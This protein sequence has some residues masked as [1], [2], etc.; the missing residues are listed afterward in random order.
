MVMGQ[1][2]GRVQKLG[3]ISIIVIVVAS[4]VLF[5]YLQSMTENNIK[6]RLFDQQKQKQLDSTMLYHNILTHL[7]YGKTSGC[8]KLCIFAEWT[9][10]R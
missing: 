1:V 9:N 10:F 6:N 5:F 3:I 8:G 7:G 2:S 4:Y